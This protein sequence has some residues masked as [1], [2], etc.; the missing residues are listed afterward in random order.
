MLERRIIPTLLLSDGDLVKPT[1]FKKTKYVG[2]PVNVVRIFNE[3]EVDELIL[4]DIS[5]G[6]FGKPPDI[7]LIEKI[8]G[9]CFMPLTYGGGI[10]TLEQA[11]NIFAA[12]V[13]KICVQSAFFSNPHFLTTLIDRFGSQSIVASIDIKLD[14]LRRPRVMIASTGSIKSV[15]WLQ[16]VSQLATAGVGEILLTAVDRDGTFLGPNL[17]LVREATAI[18]EI[19]IVSSGG[20]GSLQDIRDAFEAGASAVAAGAFF[21]YHGPH[22]AVLIT[23]PSAQELNIL[24]NIKEY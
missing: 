14:W 17:D 1:R 8:S 15:N 11:E 9:E 16:L 23:Y 20:I 12:G 24:G 7:R 6:K 2:D 22:R 10:T 21:V 13:E 5:A 4:L 19:P 18:T 3:K